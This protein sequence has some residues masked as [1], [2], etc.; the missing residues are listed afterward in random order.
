MYQQVKGDY[1]MIGRSLY[2]KQGGAFVH[3]AI[4]PP[5]VKG[6]DAAV[7]WYERGEWEE[8]ADDSREPQA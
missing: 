3:V 4:V 5:R 7:A 2:R 1:R 8:P 6:I